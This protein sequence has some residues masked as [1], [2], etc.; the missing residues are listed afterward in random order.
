MV[1]KLSIIASW[2]ALIPAILDYALL[3]ESAIKV[4]SIGDLALL[5]DDFSTREL[6]SQL[7]DGGAHTT[8]LAPD[9]IVAVLL[10]AIL[11]QQHG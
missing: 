9:G 1:E 3:L 6:A 5:K 8:T 7:V 2:S 4:N 10:S 11:Q